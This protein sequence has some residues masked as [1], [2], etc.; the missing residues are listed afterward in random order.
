MSGRKWMVCVL[1]LVPLLVSAYGDRPSRRARH[2]QAAPETELVFD[3]IKYRLINPSSNLLELIDGKT[4]AGTFSIPEKITIQ[5]KN[6]TVTSI[7]NE[8]FYESTGLTS[9]VIPNSVT[10]IGDLAFG[11]CTRLSSVEIPNSV[12]SIGTGAFY[13]CNALKAITIP[14]SVTMIGNGAF[15]GCTGLTSVRVPNP[16]ASIGWEAFGSCSNLTSATIP[17]KYRGDWEGIFRFCPKLK[18]VNFKD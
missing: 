12:V 7:G 9:V 13:G 8:A 3:Q 11:N 15:S 17:E 4:A 6:Y 10:S 5:D 1:L 14:Q 16:D 2:G 18:N